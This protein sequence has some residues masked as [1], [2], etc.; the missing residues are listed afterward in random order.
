MLFLD[1]FTTYLKAWRNQNGGSKR[2]KILPRLE[3]AVK[4]LPNFRAI[5]IRWREKLTTDARCVGVSPEYYIH[6]ILQQSFW[7]VNLKK[8]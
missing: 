8:N 4:R 1:I 6:G 5:Y 3:E 7:G 2:D